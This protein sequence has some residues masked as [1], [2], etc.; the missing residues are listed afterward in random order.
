MKK[1]SIPLLSTIFSLPLSA[2]CLDGKIR[3]QHH[4]KEVV[5]NE[6][7]CY[8]QSLK[9][10][11]S[12]KS[13]GV[14]K[15]CQYKNLGTIELK[16]SEIAGETGSLGFKICEKYR[17]TPQVI[18]FLLDNKWVSS[19]R[20]LFSDGSFIDNASLAQKVKYVD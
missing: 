12:N 18:E 2:G 16:M 7:Y 20:C 8:E 15:V 3:Y 4:G 6:S 19:S 14:N 17:G 13:C 11:T 9:L 10:L 5:V 1:V